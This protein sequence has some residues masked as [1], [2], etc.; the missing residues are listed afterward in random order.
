MKNAEKKIEEIRKIL[1]D[2]DLCAEAMVAEIG[3]IVG[4]IDTTSEEENERDTKVI[5]SALFPV[6]GRKSFNGKA[7]LMLDHATGGRYLRSYYTTVAGFV[8]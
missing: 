6:N 5:I 7:K 2:T 3:G 4:D 1:C 8:G